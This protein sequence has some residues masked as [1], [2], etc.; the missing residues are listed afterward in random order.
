M[1]SDEEI[2][3]IYLR[4]WELKQDEDFWAFQEADE[5]VRYD[6]ERGWR[7]TRLLISKATSDEALGYV[8]AGPLE[9]LI[10][11]RGSEFMETVASAARNDKRLQLA[12][13]GV[14]L[15]QGHPNR[16]RW[17]KLMQEFGFTSGR[18]TPFWSEGVPPD[19]PD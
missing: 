19:I 18:Q 12:L 4:H 17:L 6:P 9:D 2:A 10:H 1:H 3:D 13:T 5:I 8:A 15:G 11:S 16:E 7:L 14:W